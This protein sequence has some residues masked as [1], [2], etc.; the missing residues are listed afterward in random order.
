MLQFT[1]NDSAWEK[2]RSDALAG[3][4]AIGASATLLYAGQFQLIEG[5]QANFL[6]HSGG[7]GLISCL[8]LAE[9]RRR[10][11]ER[12]IRQL[13]EAATTDPLTGAGNR[14]SF[15]Q[16]LSRRIIQFQRYN[17]PC[18]LLIIDA[19]HFKMVNDTYGHDAGDE[20]LK[21]LVRTMTSTL[22]EIDLL[23]RIG[24][25]EFAALLPETEAFNAAIAAERIRAAVSKLDIQIPGSKK[26]IKVS[27]SI[28]GSAIQYVDCAEHWQKRADLALFQAKELGRN[29]IE[30]SAPPLEDPSQ[31]RSREGIASHAD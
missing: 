28:G 21:A 12:E 31:T 2:I 15:D 16:E 6:V 27:V 7:I 13:R 10:N 1:L 17:T 19:D 8:G 26:R 18:S 14:R 9:I 23:F 29:R 20:V 30:I 3:W 5:W 22:R 11:N 25:E 24:G 4:V